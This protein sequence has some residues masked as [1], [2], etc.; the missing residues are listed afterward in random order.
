MTEDELL[1]AVMDL[2]KLHHLYVHHCRPART[3]RGWRTPIQGLAG[4]PDLVIVGKSVLY[5]ELK[6]AK[7][8]LTKEQ[9]DWIDAL[10]RSGH[11]TGV[12]RPADLLSGLVAHQLRSVKR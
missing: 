5:R 12:W 2:A 10:D 1:A 7:G 3:E 9:A 11:N 6:S 4:F 8:R